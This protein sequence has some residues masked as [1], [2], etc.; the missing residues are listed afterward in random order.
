MAG[1]DIMSL[2][3]AANRERGVTVILVTHSAIAA[4]YG[5]RVLTLRDGV[6]EDEV[7]TR[8]AKEPRTLRPVP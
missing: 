1:A 6:V 3:R 8:P 2:L 7:I 4:A 5:D